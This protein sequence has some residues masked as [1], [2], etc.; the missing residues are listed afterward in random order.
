MSFDAVVMNITP[1]ITRGSVCVTPVAPIWK[2]HA[3]ASPVTFSVL[4]M[5]SF[6]KCR[7]V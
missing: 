3:G 6:E 1:S 4:I 5:S 7:F 2:I